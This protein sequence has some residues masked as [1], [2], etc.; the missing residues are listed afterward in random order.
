M[1][2]GDRSKSNIF[3][4]LV[5]FTLLAGLIALAM[6]LV[7]PSNADAAIFRQGNRV[8][9]ERGEIINDDLY[10]A[11]STIRIDGTVNGDLIAAGNSITVNG[12]VQGSSFLVGSDIDVNSRIQNSVRVAG[13]NVTFSAQTGRDLIA[14]GNFVT[15][16]R[17]ANISRDFI[18]GGNDVRLDGSIGR[19]MVGGASMMD[20]NGTVS[21]NVRLD[22]ENLNV[23]SNARVGGYLKY[24]SANEAKIAQGANI[25]GEVDRT[26][27][28]RYR[29]PA[30][31]YIGAAIMSFLWVLAL[32]VVLFLLFPRFGNG[33][34]RKLET[35]PWASLG[36]GFLL[37]ILTPFAV[38]LLMIT[39]IGIPTAFILLFLYI[40]AIYVAKIYVGFFVGSRIFAALERVTHWF[41]PLLFGLLIVVIISAIPFI[42]WLISLAILLFG[43]G[44]I[45]LTLV[46][47][48]RDS[49]QKQTGPIS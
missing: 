41:W 28:R 48:H 21:G 9:V 20:I 35:K 15:I 43:L 3:S 36:W 1:I 31:S 32:G 6:V 26:E 40:I 13:Q 49:R 27:R 38:L 14:A 22:V 12:D 45:V 19:N 30:V 34:N 2:I 16:T 37:L 25:Q 5:S 18:I 23:G 44:A 33:S 11:G 7:Q 42:G 10:I 47:Y 8:V 46:D 39:V 4:Y 29:R 24:K 17:D